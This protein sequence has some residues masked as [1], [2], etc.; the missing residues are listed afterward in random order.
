MG[1]SVMVFHGIKKE[2]N[3]ATK[4]QGGRP[5]TTQEEKEAIL[6]KLRPYLQAGLSVYKACLE[7]KI[8]TSTV[9]DIIRDD[10]EFSEEIKRSKQF[11]SVVINNSMT[12]RLNEIVKKQ[13]KNEPLNARDEDFLKWFAL[14]SSIT[15]E[16]FGKRTEVVSDPE[17]E[18]KRLIRIIEEN[19]DDP[20]TTQ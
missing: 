1:I 8:P 11:L 13:D 10:D 15:R 19:T 14:N 4:N 2:N 6:R 16:E 12:R 7:A 17:A 20:E 5:K 18:V 3:M 9:Y